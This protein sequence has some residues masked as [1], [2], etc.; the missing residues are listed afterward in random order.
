MVLNLCVVQTRT[1]KHRNAP[2]LCIL[3]HAKK[4]ESRFCASRK[5]LLIS[6]DTELIPGLFAQSDSSNNSACA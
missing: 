2:L 1:A 5:K 4:G 6:G 3:Y